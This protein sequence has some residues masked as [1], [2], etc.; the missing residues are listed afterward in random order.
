MVPG[1]GGVRLED[2]FVSRDEPGRLVASPTLL[3]ARRD[4]VEVQLRVGVVEA[5]AF[6]GFAERQRLEMPSLVA[7]FVVTAGARDG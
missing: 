1:V 6:G 5:R 2:G 4:V 3:V 7:G